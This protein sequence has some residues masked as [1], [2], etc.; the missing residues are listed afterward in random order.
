MCELLRVSQLE[1]WV[2][3]YSGTIDTKKQR[4]KTRDQAYRRCSKSRGLSKVGETAVEKQGGGDMK[5]G[6][7][8]LQVA[9]LSLKVKG[10]VYVEG[11]EGAAKPYF[12]FTFFTNGE[13]KF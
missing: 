7:G 1:Q 2:R 13:F 11:R 3:N 12:L 5:R 9:P 10:G 8:L 6:G 4:G